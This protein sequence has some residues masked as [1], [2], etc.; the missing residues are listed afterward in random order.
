MT[1]TVRKLTIFNV[2]PSDCTHT[3]VWTNPFFTSVL[4]HQTFNKC[5]WHL[6]LKT[7]PAYPFQCCEVI[8]SLFPVLLEHAS[9]GRLQELSI[10]VNEN[11][12]HLCKPNLTKLTEAVGTLLQFKFEI[13]SSGNSYWT[14]GDGS[15]YTHIRF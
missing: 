6:R 7:S 5:A 1:A 14:F 9:L 4:S 2:L 10:T 12:E 15:T 3:S 13:S 11:I 8:D